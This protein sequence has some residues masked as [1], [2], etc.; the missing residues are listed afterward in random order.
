MWQIARRWV[1]IER[2]VVDLTLQRIV[3]GVREIVK[4]SSHGFDFIDRFLICCCCSIN[5]H[6]QVSRKIPNK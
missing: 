1:C 5:V 3:V 2:L 4:Y 6:F